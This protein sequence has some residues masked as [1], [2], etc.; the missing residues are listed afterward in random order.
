MSKA[1]NASLPS[2]AS[3]GRITFVGSGPG[4]PGLLTVRAREA[5]SSAPL[6]ITDA[7]V[8]PEILGLVGEHTEIRPAVGEPAEVAAA[9]LAE[10]RAGNPVVRLVSGDPLTAD[11]V[12][13]EARDVAATDL[14]FDVVPGLTAGTAVPSYAGVPL[15]AAHTEADVRGGVDY[16]R[17]ATAPGPLVLHATADHLAELA[18]SLTE[19]G[20]AAQTPVTVTVDGTR[21][22]QRT[23]QSTLANLPVDAGDMSGRWCCASA[24]TCRPAAR[25]RGGSPARCTA[26]ACSYP[27]RRTRPAR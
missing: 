25:C 3:Q 21:P 13:A 11:A 1:A 10:A 9:L 19:Y 14:R 2:S 16:V 15:G 26:G 4:D 5:L 17:L 24:R 23:V 27:A 6:V 8:P 12:V 20:M 22:T 18:T 7:E